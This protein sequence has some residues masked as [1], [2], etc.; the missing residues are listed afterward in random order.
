[1]HCGVSLSELRGALVFHR[2]CLGK[3]LGHQKYMLVF[4]GEF[5]MG[6]CS[7]SVHCTQCWVS[8]ITGVG[9]R[10]K[11]WGGKWDGT[12]GVANSC[13]CHGTVVKVVLATMCLGL[14]PHCRGRMSKSSVANF[15]LF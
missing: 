5:S 13:N 10:V 11:Q 7:S 4:V 14:L 15:V 6:M 8:L 3:S 2:K 9:Y 1:M 12:M